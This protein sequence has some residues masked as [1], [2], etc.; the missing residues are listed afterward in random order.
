MKDRLFGILFVL[1]S[2]NA[3][4]ELD[5]QMV[6]E[7]SQMVNETTYSELKEECYRVVYFFYRNLSILPWS[8]PKQVMKD[9]LDG[10]LTV[11]LK[12]PESQRLYKKYEDLNWDIHEMMKLHLSTDS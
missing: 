3:L 10:Y 2:V 8:D 6:N 4:E 9:Y 11:D 7:T 5:D 1:G 12:T